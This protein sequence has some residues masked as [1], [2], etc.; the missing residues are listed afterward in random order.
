M[1]I[2]SILLGGTLLYFGG[3]WLV[4]DATQLAKR[5]GVSP[6]VIGLPL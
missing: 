6:L 5:F 2:L 4:S 3:D 1:S